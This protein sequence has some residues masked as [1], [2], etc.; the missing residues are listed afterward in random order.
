MSG[1]RVKL[2]LFGAGVALVLIGLGTIA[3]TMSETVLQVG[4]A[5]AIAGILTCAAGSIAQDVMDKS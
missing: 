5:I 1:K 4:V 3:N 2:W